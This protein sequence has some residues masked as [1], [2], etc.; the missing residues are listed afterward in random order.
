MVA[1]ESQIGES[2]LV[3]EVAV[4]DLVVAIAQSRHPQVYVRQHATQ[5]DAGGRA[6]QRRI[7]EHGHEREAPPQGQV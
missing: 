3:Q 6:E 5:I 2:L 7:G 4:P 1:G